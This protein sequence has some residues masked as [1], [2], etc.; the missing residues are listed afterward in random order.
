[1]HTMNSVKGNPK[2]MNKE[3]NIPTPKHQNPQTVINF[4]G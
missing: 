1:M 2:P 3:M 4:Q